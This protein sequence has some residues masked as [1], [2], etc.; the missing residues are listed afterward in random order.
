[1]TCRSNTNGINNSFTRITHQ[2][3][4]CAEQTPLDVFSAFGVGTS[5]AI[6]SLPLVSLVRR[7]LPGVPTVYL[8]GIASRLTVADNQRYPALYSEEY[9]DAKCYST[10][11]GTKV[12][13]NFDR[14]TDAVLI[15]FT[16]P[17]NEC[18][19]CG[20][21]IVADE[22]PQVTDYRS[23]SIVHTYHVVAALPMP[24]PGW[25][26]PRLPPARVARGS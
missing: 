24:V 25:P 11:L 19:E 13:F 15:G 26:D 6:N 3:L 10:I 4:L 5:G 7:K 2:S 23:V 16:L 9:D 22:I 14:R 17:G 1:M 12:S 20:S 8:E 18:F 21:A